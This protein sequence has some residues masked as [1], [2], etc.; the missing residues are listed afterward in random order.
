M[1]VGAGIHK[2]GI[3]FRLYQLFRPVFTPSWMGKEK[4]KQ[5]PKSIR[6]TWRYKTGIVSTIA[7]T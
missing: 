1:V 3:A 2:T 7:E 5:Y 6:K 4:L